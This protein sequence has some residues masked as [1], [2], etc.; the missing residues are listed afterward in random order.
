MAKGYGFT[1]LICRVQELLII[2]KPGRE[3]IPELLIRA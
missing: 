1:T 2:E 3:S